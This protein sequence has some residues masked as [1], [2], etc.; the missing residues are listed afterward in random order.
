MK[1]SRT[2]VTEMQQVIYDSMTGNTRKLAEAMAGEM[3]VKAVDAKAASIDRDPGVLFLGSGC[4]G[5]K[6]GKNMEKFIETNDL[7]GRK[8]AL[9]GTSGGGLGMEVKSM[10]EAL[11]RKGAIVLGS[12]YCRGKVMPALYLIN[13]S[14]PNA[15]DIDSARKFAREMSGRQQKP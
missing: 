8:V 13:M 11:K 15:A 1:I 10:E 6:P 2:G 12:Y 5:G 14:R 9:F 7:T 3:G 4:Y